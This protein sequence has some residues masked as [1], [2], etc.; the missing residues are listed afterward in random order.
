MSK[1]GREP[2]LLLLE[3]AELHNDRDA[4]RLLATAKLDLADVNDEL[5]KRLLPWLL[6]EPAELLPF[7]DDELGS[8]DET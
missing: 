8:K 5:L 7:I 3:L 2:L 6:I 1:M 4:Q